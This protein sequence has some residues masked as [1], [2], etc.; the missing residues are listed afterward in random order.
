MERTFWT[1]LCTV[2]YS[3]V[4]IQAFINAVGWRLV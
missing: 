1:H 3:R 2:V 4:G